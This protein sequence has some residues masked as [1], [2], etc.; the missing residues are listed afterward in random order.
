MIQAVKKYISK[1]NA[2]RLLKL[3]L[4][5]ALLI[6]YFADNN[7]FYLG[8][9]LLFLLQSI[10]NVGCCMGGNCNTTAPKDDKQPAFKFKELKI[11]K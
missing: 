10:F 4:G 9:S 2:S 6:G 8:F 11:K 1:W 7:S 3:F 5:I